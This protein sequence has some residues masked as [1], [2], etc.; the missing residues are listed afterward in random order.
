MTIIC[1]N[2]SNFRRIEP[3]RVWPILTKQ[4]LAEDEWIGAKRKFV[5]C[6]DIKVLTNFYLII[7]PIINPVSEYDHSDIVGKASRSLQKQLKTEGGGT[8]QFEHTQGRNT[9][10]WAEFGG[11]SHDYGR[12]NP[13]ILQGPH[14]DD[15][16]QALQCIPDEK[17]LRFVWETEVYR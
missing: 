10:W 1:F 17:A 15:L 4:Q 5:L 2:G 3:N 12:Y 6:S 11:Y 8:I 16:L 13:C 7:G 9:E 14:L